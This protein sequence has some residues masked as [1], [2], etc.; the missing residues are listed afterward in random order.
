[1]VLEE[2]KQKEQERKE[3][4]SLMLESSPLLKK[5]QVKRSYVEMEQQ[6]KVES[7]P[8]QKKVEKHQSKASTKTSTTRT[9][10]IISTFRSKR[11]KL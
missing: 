5:P 11:R 7:K 10:S 2:K 1:M 3:K 9:P 8:V 4:I 6:H